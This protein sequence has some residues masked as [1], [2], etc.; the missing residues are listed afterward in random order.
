MGVRWV[1]G[2]GVG[3][4]NGR[5]LGARDGESWGGTAAVNGKTG[6]CLAQGRRQQQQ[7]SRA[8]EINSVEG[9]ALGPS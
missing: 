1:C 2:G 3:P 7:G 4:G 6:V 5:D 8:A 9:T